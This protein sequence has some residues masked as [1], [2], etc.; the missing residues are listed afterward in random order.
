MSNPQFV[1]QASRARPSRG[2]PQDDQKGIA[3]DW[4]CVLTFSD[5]N[6]A[7]YREFQDTASEVEATKAA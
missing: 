6:V 5:G 4:P 1:R 3:S 7:A 2:G